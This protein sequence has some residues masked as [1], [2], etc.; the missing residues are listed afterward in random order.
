MPIDNTSFLSPL[1]AAFTAAGHSLY[2]VGGYVRNRLLSLPTSD[3]DVA[4]TATPDEALQ[5]AAAAGYQANMRS[6]ILGTVDLICEAGRVE[7]TPFRIE[8]YPE[9]GSHRPCAVSFTKSMLLDARRRDFTVNA[10]YQS[11]ESGDILDPLGGLSDL[12][13]HRLRACGAVA[14]DTLKDDGLRILRMVRFCG[15]LGFTP[16]GDLLSASIQYAPNLFDL[17]PSRIFG[18]WRRICLCDAK[19]PSFMPSVDKPFL[20]I[21]LLHSCGALKALM[22]TLYEGKGLAQNQTYHRYDVFDHNLHTFSSAPA[23][24]ALRTAALLHDIGKPYCAKLLNNGHMHGH[25]E[26]GVEFSRPILNTLGIPNALQNE[27]LLLI[28]RHMFDLDGRAKESTVRIRFATWGFEFAKRLLLL[29]QSDIKGSGL[30]QRDGTVEK[31]EAILDRMRK[32]GVVDDPHLLAI[33]GDDIMEACQ[34]RGGPRVG[35]IKQLLFERCALSPKM[36]S[37]EALLREAVTLNRQLSQS[38]DSF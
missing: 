26:K 37:R 2:L 21:D 23:D 10:L 28:E 13:D 19:Y 27:I 35:R 18:E 30:P 6:C 9:G 1:S 11:I 8:S 31:W 25:P 33:N 7:Y 29:R 20:A 34:L 5:L 16:D 4:G 32:E 38:V 12:R 3:I 15:E 24:V 36:N 14:A 22:P 17:S